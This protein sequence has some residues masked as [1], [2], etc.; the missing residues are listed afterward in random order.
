MNRTAAFLLLIQKDE[1]GAV[2]QLQ[3]ALGRTPVAQ[4]SSVPGARR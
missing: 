3:V 4:P 1:A 2:V